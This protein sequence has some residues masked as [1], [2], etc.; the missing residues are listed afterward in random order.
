MLK[1]NLQ[2]VMNDS[3]IEFSS[4]ESAQTAVIVLRDHP[5]VFDH[6]RHLF[7]EPDKAVA[8]IVPVL[9]SFK[10]FVPPKVT[11]RVSRKL[12]GG[13][14]AADLQAMKEVFTHAGARAVTIE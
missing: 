10:R 12:A 2:V 4:G 1:N 11:V 3:Q 8:V 13:L 14:V 5:G 7:P 9:R 6:P